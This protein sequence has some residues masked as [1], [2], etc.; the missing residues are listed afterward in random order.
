M[1]L[2]SGRWER[3]QLG[4]NLSTKVSSYSSAKNRT[5]KNQELSQQGRT[6]HF[7]TSSHVRSH[8]VLSSC[9]SIHYLKYYSASNFIH[10]NTAFSQE[11]EPAFRGLPSC[12]V[13]HKPEHKHHHLPLQTVTKQ[14]S[15]SQLF[16]CQK[17]WNTTNTTKQQ[18]QVARKREI[19]R[20]GREGQ[21]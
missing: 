13:F 4:E 7:F 1:K 17:Q 16:H 21:K 14:G 10:R 11:F 18:L 12:L 5:K 2:G 20:G 9:Q 19:E 8:S 15:C 3:K 6:R